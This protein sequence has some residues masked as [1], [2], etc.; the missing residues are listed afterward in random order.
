MGNNLQMTLLKNN[1]NQNTFKISVNN[2][3]KRNKKKLFQNMKQLF[4]SSI[5]RHHHELVRIGRN[6]QKRVLI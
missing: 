6:A 4:F 1:F 5:L 2:L 3:G